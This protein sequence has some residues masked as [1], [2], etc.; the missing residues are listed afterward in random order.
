MILNVADLLKQI[1]VCDPYAQNVYNC[2]NM[3]VQ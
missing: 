2:P 1:Y 3:G